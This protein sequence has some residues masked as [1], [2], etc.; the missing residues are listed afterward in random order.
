MSPQIE[1]RREGMRQL[2]LWQLGQRGGCGTAPQVA[3]ALGKEL[4]HIW[5]RFTE[6]AAQRKI[7]DTGRRVATK[8]RPQIIWID[9]SRFRPATNRDTTA[10]PRETQNEEPGWFKNFG[11]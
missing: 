1:A 9:Q 10:I 3:A 8:G 2:I 5:P 6:L 7:S 11:T 4:K